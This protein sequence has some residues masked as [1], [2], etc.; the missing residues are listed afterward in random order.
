MALFS[1][2]PRLAA[3]IVS[4]ALIGAGTYGGLLGLRALEPVLPAHLAHI[5]G[6]IVAV[7][8]NGMFAVQVPGKASLLWFRPAPGAPISLAHLWRHVHERAGTDVFYQPQPQGVPLAWE[9][10]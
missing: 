5:H 7:R 3:W 8:M 9:A 4:L 10:D 6:V 1:R 2:F